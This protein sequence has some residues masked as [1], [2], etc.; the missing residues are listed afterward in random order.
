MHAQE[1]L[2][3]GASGFLGRHVVRAA[4]EQ[5]GVH[6][7]SRTGSESW[8]GSVSHERWSTPDWSALE[9]G[10]ERPG[11][12]G[13]LS[14]AAL[15]RGADCEAEP[16]RASELNEE[17]PRRLARA[18]SDR[19]LR[20][21]HVSTD[22]VFGC[23][24]PPRGGFDEEAIPRPQGV[25]AQTKRRGE[26]AVL[27]EAP[28]A[29]VVRLPLLYGDSFGA[30]QG[31][32][33]S[34]L[35]GLASGR[36]ARLFTD[37]LRTPAD[38]FEVARALVEL[39]LGDERG[40]LHLGGPQPI[41]RYELGLAILEAAGW[42]LREG[43]LVAVRSAETPAV[44]PRPLDSSLDST[45]AGRLLSRAISAPAAA[46]RARPPRLERPQQRRRP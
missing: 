10:L 31:A 20:L 39:C 42:E 41:S 17:L 12:R 2:V 23:Q 46:L 5:G 45:R 15:A 8:P 37:E 25:Y 32:S 18:C 33:D 21:V 35:A 30:G 26:L 11:L 40:L 16:E 14:C 1:L 28:E 43:D 29:L 44:P 38:V 9:A 27:A 7:L 36:P 22:L 13:V 19:G 6:C 34:L 3:L 24:T 4:A